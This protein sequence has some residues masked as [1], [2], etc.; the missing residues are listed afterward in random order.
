M[1][2]RTL[3]TKIQLRN[4]T[5]ENWKTTNPKLLKGEIGIE[6]NTMKLKIGDGFNNWNA[7]SY[8][9][10]TDLSEYYN[11]DEIDD[12]TRVIEDSVDNINVVLTTHTTATNPHNVTASQV[13][14]Y[15][16]DETDDLLDDKVD[17]V[18]GKGLSTNDYTTA[19]KT[20]LAGIEEGANNYVLPSDVVQDSAYV[21]TDNNY[22]TAEKTKLSGIEAGANN[23]VLP[24]DVVKDS[25]YV[26]TDNNFTDGE[27]TK[28]AGIE[29]NA[30]VN[31][32]E[33]IYLGTTKLNPDSTK[34]VTIPVVTSV[35]GTSTSLITAGG[36]KSTTDSISGDLTTHKN[37]KANPHNVT[38]TQIGLGDVRNVESYSKGETD[39]L[40]GDKLDASQ[41][42]ALF[43][44]ATLDGTGKI[45]YTQL[46]DIILGQLV[47]GGNV[48][49]NSNSQIVAVLTTNAKTK[50]S[51]AG[52]DIE[53]DSFVLYD[54]E[55][56]RKANE[57]IFYIAT[58]SFTFAEKTFVA[59]DWLISTG[60]VWDK[61]DNTDAV[62]GVKGNSETSYRTGN[63]NITKANIGLD[64]VLNVA[65]YAKTETYSKTEVDNLKDAQDSQINEN[66]E[67]IQTISTE[68]IPALQQ[69][70]TFV[71]NGLET[72]S[73]TRNQQVEAINTALEGKSDTDHTHDAVT[74]NKAGFMTTTQLQHLIDA[75][76]LKHSHDNKDVLDTYSFSNQDVLIAIDE[77]HTHANIAVL[78]NTQAAF[79]SALY[80]KLN[81]IAEGA[82]KTV[83]D[84]AINSNST[85]PVQNKVIANELQDIWDEIRDIPSITVDTAIST[86]STN[87]VQNKV[88]TAKFQDIEDAIGDIEN[89]KSES[90]VIKLNGTC[91]FFNA[92]GDFTGGTV[93]ITFK[94]E[95]WNKFTKY[96]YSDVLLTNSDSSRETYVFKNYSVVDNEDGSYYGHYYYEFDAGRRYILAIY[97]SSTKMQ[98]D[99]YVPE[100]VE[101]IAPT[102]ILILNCGKADLWSREE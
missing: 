84:T 4:D 25:S 3:N 46:P 30:A 28:L 24:A 70:I 88:I 44:V 67:A 99:E 59:G 47:Y 60:I 74:V 64:N 92:N 12:I 23:Y 33:S 38:K 86:T 95:D 31:I 90:T 77:A 76:G 55:S 98:V 17:K 18:T 42:G 83:V 85:N 21:H 54:T 1:A 78:N 19:E 26:H 36:V 29:S 6:I 22:T 61:V 5:A 16:K 35:S 52:Y 75:Y 68:T 96:K 101:T 50:L 27:K 11:R 93:S 81:G 82:N 43:G 56:Y 80:N 39:D 20:K 79:T 49:K 34:K 2:E 71:S 10:I 97:W 15:S 53:S 87:P 13:G 100:T 102:D 41:K 48:S 40:L 14:A 9:N 63:V 91:S 58:N 72:E 66:F 37:N 7:L 8:A 73:S 51:N 89:R 65:S 94:T 57:G 45:I 62:T 32:V 69:S